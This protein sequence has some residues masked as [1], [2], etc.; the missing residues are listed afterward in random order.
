[1]QV[2]ATPLEP[3]E[4]FLFAVTRATA[5]PSE[6]LP[7]AID[8]PLRRMPTRRRRQESGCLGCPSTS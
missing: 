1:V 7:V 2:Y 5:D 4:R 8:V 6:R 3:H